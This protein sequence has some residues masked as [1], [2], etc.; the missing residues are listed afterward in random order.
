MLKRGKLLEVCYLFF[1]KSADKEWS[2]GKAQTRYG[3]IEVTVY[4]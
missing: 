3:S 4:V 1:R 2:L